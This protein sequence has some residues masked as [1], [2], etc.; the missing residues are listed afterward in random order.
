MSK[1]NETDL[2]RRLGLLCEIEPSPQRAGQALD[3]VRQML[4]RPTPAADHRRTSLWRIVERNWAA[5]LA[6]AAAIVLVVL[7]L[8]SLF[9]GRWDGTT[10]AYA[11]VTE[12]VRRVPWMHVRYSGYHLDAKGNRTTAEGQLDT[13]IWYSFNAQVMIYRYAG[14]EIDYYDYARQEIQKYN[15][16]AKR[17][18]V[19]ALP[20]D[21]RPFRMDSPAGWLEK[22]IEQITSDGGSVTRETGQ[23]EGREAEVFEITAAVRPEVATIH[24]RIFVDRATFL[25]IAEEK[26]AINPKTGSPQRVET[27][28]FDCPEQGP[29]DIYAL[30]LPRDV[31]T[32]SSLPLPP[33]SEFGLA[34]ESYHREPPAEK[35]AAVVTREMIGLVESV[36][37][38]YAD[39]VHFREEQHS[40]YHRGAIGAQWEE[41]KGEFGDTLDSILKWSRA[42]KAYGAISIS[43]FDGDHR[44]SA[45]R[46]EDGAWSGTE[47]I[48]SDGGLTAEDFWHLSH[49]A[50]LGWPEIC[51]YA[52]IIQDDYARDNGLIRVEVDAGK[53]VL[54]LNPDRDYICEQSIPLE[55]QRYTV[56]EFGRTDTG[57]WYPK[58]IDNDGL[59]YT[60]YL[61]TNPEFPEGLFDPNSL[62]K[63]NHEATPVP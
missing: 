30:G 59:K 63:A 40:L 34:Y 51:G 48:V 17:I 31:P 13:E 25:P 61:E 22:S 10:A 33:W 54:Y 18:V 49:V 45:R 3:R 1:M 57:R 47:Q 50:Q 41:Q 24:S 4:S 14:G 46:D 36:Q 38:C 29:A 6:S 62:P 37:I 23:Y 27:G 58:R 21:M 16:I 56:L 42:H 12:A 20:A 44:Y 55:G 9:A 32:I 28:T 8:L 35:Y 7:L 60:V 52:D 5:G 53:G 26:A 15:P 19:S 39:G 43:L 2:R 11:K